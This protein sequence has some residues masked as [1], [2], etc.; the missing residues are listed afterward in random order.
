[1]NL[2]YKDKKILEILNDNARL[3]IAEIS[4]KTGIQRDSVINRINMNFMF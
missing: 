3:T 4:R 1:M 2:D